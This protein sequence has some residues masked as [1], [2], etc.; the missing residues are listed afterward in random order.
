MIQQQGLV[1]RVERPWHLAV[2][3]KRL[4]ATI[5]VIR[6]SLRIDPSCVTYLINLSASFDELESWHGRYSEPR[7][8]WLHLVYIHFLPLSARLVPRPALLT[9]NL[10]WANYGTSVIIS[11]YI[12]SSCHRIEDLPC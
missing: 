2:E 12:V 4:L 11:L 8:E 1:Q 9:M 6:R 5:S 10:A 3:E 7:S